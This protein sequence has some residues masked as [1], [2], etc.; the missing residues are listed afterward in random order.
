MLYSCFVCH[1]FL[2]NYTFFQ[3]CQLKEKS[4]SPQQ[5]NNP[6]QTTDCTKDKD[7]VSKHLDLCDT[8]RLLLFKAVNIVLSYF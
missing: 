1:Y 7:A 6:K 5:S 3:D 8:V 2:T 4:G